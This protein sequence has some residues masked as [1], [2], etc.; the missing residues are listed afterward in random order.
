MTMASL[1]ART[2]IS[3]LMLTK[4]RLGGGSFLRNFATSTGSA[5]SKIE[6]VSK[7]VSG[8]SPED[9]EANPQIA[10]FL[11]ANFEG[12]SDEIEDGFLIPEEILKKF[13]VT[14]SDFPVLDKGSQKEYGAPKLD[15]GLGS[16]EQQGLNIRTLH[17]FLRQEEGSN[18]CRRLRNDKIIPGMLYGG[19]PNK[20]INPTNGESK[21]LLKTPWPELQRELDRFHRRF[22]SRVYD[23]TIYEDETDTEGSIHRVVPRNV[24]RH[25][26]QGSIYCANFVRYYPGRPLKI[27]IIYVNTEESPALKRDGFIIP[28]SKHVECIVEDGVAIPDVIELECTDVQLKDVLRMD[29]LIFPDGVRP[30]DRVDPEKFVIGPVVGGRGSGVDDEEEGE[31]EEA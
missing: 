16:Q 2:A 28:V 20:G 1:G 25:P 27:P 3:R 15:R 30:T 24:Q 4:R 11:Q 19:D 18:E 29:R 8:L 10:E 31:S 17:S 7:L 22:E 21:L 13:G 12:E 23:L 26:V 6:D 5:A 9:V 14:D